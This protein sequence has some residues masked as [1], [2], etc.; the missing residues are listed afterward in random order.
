M[1][2]LLPRAFTFTQAGTRNLSAPSLPHS[3][4]SKAYISSSERAMLAPRWRIGADSRRR[5]DET[6]KNKDLKKASN[7]AL[8]TMIA[9]GVAELAQRKHDPT[10]SPRVEIRRIN[11]GQPQATITVALEDAK[12][13]IPPLLIAGNATLNQKRQHHFEAFEV[14]AKTAS[15]INR[16]AYRE[17]SSGVLL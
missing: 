13:G 10:M 5:K 2:A 15:R 12:P 14:D 17:N 11:G 16:R 6:M 4:N 3:Q 9:L 1:F 7:S 8:W